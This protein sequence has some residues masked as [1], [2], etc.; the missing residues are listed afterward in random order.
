MYKEVISIRGDFTDAFVNLAQIFIRRGQIDE[1]I[2]TYELAFSRNI[3]LTD[4]MVLADLYYNVAA[5]KQIKLDSKDDLQFDQQARRRMATEIAHHFVQALDKNP[6]HHKALINFAILLQQDNFLENEHLLQFRQYLLE[7]LK[8][9]EKQDKLDLIHFNIA[10]LLLDLGGVDNRVEAMERFDQALC[11]KPD[12]RSAL[13]NMA[14][15]HFFDKHFEKS[16]EYLNRLYLFH[17]DY[18]KALLLKAAVHSELGQM[19]LA[20]H[21]SC[22]HFLFLLRNNNIV[23]FDVDL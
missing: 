3:V 22:E 12:F 19:A 17:P 6:N 13:F 2:D 9:Y 16:L 23:L 4:R 18:N 11:L 20:K 15:L 10:V 14:L 8:S 7:A 21:V 1:A 5:L